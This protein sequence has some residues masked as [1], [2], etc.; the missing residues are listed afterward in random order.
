MRF[1]ASTVVSFLTALSSAAPAV[2]EP[3]QGGEYYAVGNQYSSGGCLASS[4][5][6]ADP[7]YV[8]NGCVALNRFGTSPSIVS[9]TLIGENAGCSVKL[10]TDDTCTSPAFSAPVGGCVQGGSPFHEIFG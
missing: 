6:F 9:Y 3:R 5:I 8:K 7:I 10:Y 2:L 1:T 4:L